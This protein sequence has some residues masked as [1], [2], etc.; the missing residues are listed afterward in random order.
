MP[1]PNALAKG[2]AR[3][4]VVY[5]APANDRMQR[6]GLGFCDLGKLS[7]GVV[8]LVS[9]VV[10]SREESLLRM[11]VGTL[12]PKFNMG[13]NDDNVVGV[14]ITLA[15]GIISIGIIPMLLFHRY[16]VGKF[17][18]PHCRHGCFRIG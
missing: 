13:F 18:Q 10:G 16:R 8:D 1:S 11:G 15:I 4:G 17:V 9:D 7:S 5:N 6:L 3:K 2:D 14:A 12:R